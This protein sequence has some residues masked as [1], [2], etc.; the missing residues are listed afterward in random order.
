MLN[1]SS[2]NTEPSTSTSVSSSSSHASTSSYDLS[3]PTNPTVPFASGTTASIT[4]VVAQSATMAPAA[5]TSAAKIPTSQLSTGKKESNKGAIAGGTI[6]GLLVFF[7]LSTLFFWWLRRRR[8]SHTAPSAAYIAA[9]GT[10]RP[11]TMMSH[12]PLQGRSMSYVSSA[13]LN[14]V[15]LQDE[16]ED[17][18]TSGYSNPRGPL[19]SGPL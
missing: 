13:N 8:R 17:L 9:Y 11:P 6:A 14:S 12:R 15:V 3:A 18:R 4:G 1:S 16:S 10:S 2:T 5:S 7:T 19:A